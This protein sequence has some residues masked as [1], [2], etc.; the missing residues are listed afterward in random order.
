[1]KF[2]YAAVR[3]FWDKKDYA[4]DLKKKI[5][6]GRFFVTNRV[7]ISQRITGR[8]E[9]ETLMC[10]FFSDQSFVVSASQKIKV[11]FYF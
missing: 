2:G 5:A 1:M 9:N 4:S 8:L 6:F 7:I 11:V 3:F 10:S